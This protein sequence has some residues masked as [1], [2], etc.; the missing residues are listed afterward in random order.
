M[1]LSY[2][3][4]PKVSSILRSSMIFSYFID[5]FN[6]FF[7]KFSETFSWNVYLNPYLITLWYSNSLLCFVFQFN[8]YQYFFNKNF[9]L[10]MTQ[11]NNIAN[12]LIFSFMLFT[13]I[14]LVS[15]FSFTSKFKFA[16]L[17][18]LRWYLGSH[19]IFQFHSVFI[20]SSRIP[21]AQ[22]FPFFKFFSFLH[23]LFLNL[24]FSAL[25]SLLP[26]SY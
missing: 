13:N 24:N 26:S 16:P 1:A 10:F 9:A 4:L 20:L 17:P 12:C 18:I 15:I 3:M 19:V 23:F 2:Y 8:K 5:D 25:H 11:S 6:R 21:F 22:Y 14:F 7:D